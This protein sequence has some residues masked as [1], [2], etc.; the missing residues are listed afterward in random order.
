MDKKPKNHIRIAL[1][2]AIL[3]RGIA[4]AAAGPRTP[5]RESP[6]IERTSASSLAQ[7]STDTEKA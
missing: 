2:T 4:E 5:D 1:P 3:G 6:H 7:M